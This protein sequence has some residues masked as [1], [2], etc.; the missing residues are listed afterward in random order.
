MS[1]PVLN[2]E[3]RTLIPTR[4]ILVPLYFA[5]SYIESEENMKLPINHFD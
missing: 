5:L 2:Q 3:E 1:F 4:N